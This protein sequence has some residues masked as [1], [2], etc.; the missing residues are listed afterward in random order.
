MIWKGRYIIKRPR[1]DLE[2]FRRNV[3]SVIS[4]FF[5]PCLFILVESSRANFIKGN[6][7]GVLPYHA[8]FKLVI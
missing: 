2:E 6:K 7:P 5:N 1:S 8:A 3:S 4:Y